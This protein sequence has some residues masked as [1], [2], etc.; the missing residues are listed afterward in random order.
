MAVPSACRSVTFRYHIKTAKHIVEFF[1]TV[2]R[3][4]TSFWFVFVT[5]G[6]FKTRTGST[7]TGLKYR[8]V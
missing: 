8:R 1:F 4:V 5:N 6:C 2:G 3:T 7:L